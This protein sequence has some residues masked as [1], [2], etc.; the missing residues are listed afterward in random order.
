M[1]DIGDLIRGGGPDLPDAFEEIVDAVDVAF[2]EEPTM[3]VEGQRAVQLAG[4]GPDE[5]VG[6]ASTAEPRRFESQENQGGEVLIDE[7]NVHVLGRQPAL[8]VD[9]IGA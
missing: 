9:L 3:G 7:R 1:G 4:T 6:L 2:A 8:S 5:V